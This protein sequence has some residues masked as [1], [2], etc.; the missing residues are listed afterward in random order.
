MAS[1]QVL[2]PSM[3]GATYI[4]ILRLQLRKRYVVLVS[5]GS[6]NPPTYMHLR[7]LEL[8]RDR[9]F[10]FTRVLCIKAVSCI[11]NGAISRLRHE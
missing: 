11:K 6:F 3:F 9:C 1:Y 7:C 4:L 10:E 5:N 2:S 8:A